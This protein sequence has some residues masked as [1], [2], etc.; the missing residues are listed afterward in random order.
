MDLAL[1]VIGTIIALIGWVWLLIIAF[2]ENIGWGIGSL[3]CGIVALIFAIT[4]WPETKTP[5]LLYIA[6]ILISAIGGAIKATA[7]G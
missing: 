2:S 7:G 6:G 1:Q 3:L 5:A 4:R